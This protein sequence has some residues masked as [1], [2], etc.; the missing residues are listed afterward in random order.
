MRRQSNTLRVAVLGALLASG[1][2]LAGP[3]GA[4]TP[5]EC[6]AE[7]SLPK[8]VDCYVTA[9]LAAD[10][11]AICEAAEDSVWFRC[12]TV[13]AERRQDPAPCA[14]IDRGATESEV[15]AFRDSCVA[16]VA[17]ASAAPDLCATVATPSV[18]SVCY[19]MLVTE[20]GADPALCGQIENESLRQV[21]RDAAHE[22]G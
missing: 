11:P 22:G 12:L 17:V 8:R 19:M 18:R 13:Y 3:A 9:A 1:A 10:D 21:C 20:A 4:A 5:A 15:Q 2:A 16:G 14:R 7:P 6:A